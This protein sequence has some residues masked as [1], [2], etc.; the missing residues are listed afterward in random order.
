MSYVVKINDTA[1]DLPPNSKVQLMLPNPHLLYE[2]I[3]GPKANFPSLPFTPTNQQAFAFW[4]EPQ[5]GGA[6][7]EYR[8]SQYYSAEMVADG[9]FYLADASESGGFSGAFATK[10]GQFFGDIQNTKISEINWGSIA[11]PG[12]LTPV[13]QVSGKIA[14]CFPTIINATYY[15]QNAYAGRMNDY[16]LGAYTV[17]GPRVPMVFLSY[18]FNLIE[19]ATG[20]TI[21]GDFINDATWQQAIWYNTRALDGATTVTLANH[22]PELTI[23]ELFLEIRKLVNLSFTF[24]TITKRLTI[25]FWDACLKLPTLKDWTPK[26]VKGGN[27]IPEFNT[28]I[29]LSYD[30]DS[31]DALQKNRPADVADYLTA[32]TAD[33]QSGIAKLSCKI[34][35]LLVDAGTG[36]ATAQQ[37]GATTTY[38]QQANKFS[39][40]L[41]FWNGIVSGFPRALPTLNTTSLFWNGANGL[42]TKYWSQTETVRKRQFYLKKSFVLNEADIATLDMKR[43]I[44]VDG[45]NYLIAQLNVELPLTKPCEALLLGGV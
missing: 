30:L 14:I 12:V 11:L 29:Q 4:Q 5:A 38:G 17:T 7:Q 40:R 26:A 13:V 34:S 45:V 43:K 42:A 27:K 16:T 32:E 23:V 25:D 9:Y 19:A 6:L 20:T 35:P 41:L 44:H 21:D 22:L 28:R 24:N 3:E 36:L 18:L 33:V 1:V 10:L 31:N 39:P 37:V 15:G 8:C 2:R